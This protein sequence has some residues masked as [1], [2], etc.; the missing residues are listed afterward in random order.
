MIALSP[1]D[2]ARKKIVY[3]WLDESVN[4]AARRLA[5]ENIGSMVVDDRSG[6]HVGMLTD[7]VIF[8]AISTLADVCN[9]KVKDL[10][11][12]PLVTAK[13]NADVEEVMG[14]FEQTESSRIAL[15]DDEGQIV[16]ILKKKNLERFAIF[17]LG[18]KLY[19][20]GQYKK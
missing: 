2:Y 11:L 14:K 16:G 19:K 13:M 20:Q 7:I 8:K 15:L 3:C 18:E 12:E 9:M 10:K 5:L 17:E 6:K 4:D 1:Y